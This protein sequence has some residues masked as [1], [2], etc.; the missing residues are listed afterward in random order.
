MKEGENSGAQTAPENGGV[1]PQFSSAPSINTQPEQTIETITASSA[2]YANAFSVTSA[3][4]ND[5]NVTVGAASAIKAGQ[6][7]GDAILAGDARYGAE[8]EPKEAISS[9]PAFFA[10]EMAKKNTKTVKKAKKQTIIAIPSDKKSNK[11]KALILF[12]IAA[13]ILIVGIAILFSLTSKNQKI[14]NNSL[15]L[16]DFNSQKYE[17]LT[18]LMIQLQDN[19]EASRDESTQMD[20]AYIEELMESGLTE[21][22]SLITDFK[23]LNIKNKSD[24]IKN[25]HK[26]IA[27]RMQGELNA[28][29]GMRD[30]LGTLRAALNGD[31]EA[32]KSINEK[33]DGDTALFDIYTIYSSRNV[34]AADLAKRKKEL[35]CDAEP[36]NGFNGVDTGLLQEYYRQCDI[37]RQDLK[38]YNED[39]EWR[40]KTAV[41]V[42]KR[43]NN[44]NYS[45]EN[46]AITAANI[47]VMEAEE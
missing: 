42:K 9:A 30:E 20:S 5:K 6:G 17:N 24:E 40:L 43:L 21:Y 12:G 2:D 26:Q 38:Q 45:K 8:E 19:A 7:Q 22:N 44:P 29:T 3:T 10:Q 1:T 25:E 46:N 35:R 15:A 4:S 23:N 39:S 16:K 36:L 27:E 34:T 37:Y 41:Y 13:I 47:F 11:P 32:Q 14:G 33:A 28:L 18:S 31:S